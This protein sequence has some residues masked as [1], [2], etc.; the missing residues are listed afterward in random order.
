[1]SFAVLGY[2]TH[3]SGWLP[4]PSVVYVQHLPLRDEPAQAQHLVRQLPTGPHHLLLHKVTEDTLQST[5]G[6]ETLVFR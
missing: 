1:M 2:S 3:V 6:T 5:C 4:C